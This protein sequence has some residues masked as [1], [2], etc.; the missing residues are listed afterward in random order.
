MNFIVN[1]ICL[2]YKDCNINA[3]T[4][5]S[6]V[7]ALHCDMLSINQFPDVSIIAI[8]NLFSFDAFHL[9]VTRL[10]SLVDQL[11]SL[12]RFLVEFVLL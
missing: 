9:T 1:E 2:L 10:V 7:Y 5:C 11:S 6:G 8:M 4:T 12:P 3:M